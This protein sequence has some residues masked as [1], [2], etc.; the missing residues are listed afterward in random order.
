MSFALTANRPADPIK[1]FGNLW[2]VGEMSLSDTLGI[3]GLVVGV[4]GL[5]A[6]LIAIGY[7]RTCWR[8]VYKQENDVVEPEFLGREITDQLAEGQTP[9]ILS[10]R[11]AFW[12]AGHK[13]LNASEVV[14]GYPIRFQF[15]GGDEAVKILSLRTLRTSD[16]ANKF[17]AR[18]GSGGTSVQIKFEYLEYH[19]GGLFEIVRAG[20]AWDATSS[21]KVKGLRSGM[22][23]I[24]RSGFLWPAFV[25]VLFEVTFFGL[26]EA[27]GFAHES[28][29]T[30]IWDTAVTI[31]AAFFILLFLRSLREPRRL[32]L[33]R[34]YRGSPIIRI[35]V[36]RV[37]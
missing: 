7:E 30:R 32:S 25:M 4:A 22:R 35:T 28:L 29:S 23:E 20:G 9:R 18:I 19:Q 6:S 34:S 11:I 5:V 26:T 3:A 21:G 27:L 17:D 33:S 13:T 10:T 15:E 24:D 37:R 31:P 16:E 2:T 8:P 1:G 12:N 14:D 36:P